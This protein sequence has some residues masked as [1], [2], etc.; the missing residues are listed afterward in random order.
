MNWKNLLKVL[1]ISL[2]LV[3]VML[4]GLAFWGL[5][6]L[7]SAFEIKQ[8]LTPPALKKADAGAHGKPE[9]TTEA[10][11]ANKD[12]SPAV[13]S[14]GAPSEAPAKSNVTANTTKVLLENFTDTRKPLV[15]GCRNLAQASESHF[16]RDPESASAKY[17]FES[18][19]Q[20]QKDPL[21]ETAAP[22]LRYIFRAPGMQ[23]VIEMVMKAE[24]IKDLG[25]LKK[26]EF[27]YEIYRAGDFLKDHK[28]D[29]DV[30][31]Q[32]TYNMHHLAKAVAQKPELAKDAAT[33]SFCEQMEKNVNDSGTYNAD[34]AASEMMKFLS[35]SGIDPKS[36]DYD[37]NYRS[38]VKLNL[39]SSQVSINDTWVVKLFARDIEK[40]HKD[41]TAKN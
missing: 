23:S 13:I 36:I 10:S 18:L 39:S 11:A 33:L 3:V 31:L 22:I 25:M 32:K 29:M 30:I 34:Q 5:S 17:F 8:S 9:G 14:D 26:A 24:E 16:M 35:D 21:V 27:Y 20:E 6:K 4:G 12:E 41:P 28:D 19:A 15:E 40:A 37:P 38:K 7:P 2:A 1:S